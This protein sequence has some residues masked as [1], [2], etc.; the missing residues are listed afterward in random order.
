MSRPNFKPVD[1]FAD[2]TGRT[3]KVGDQ[4]AYAVTSGNMAELKLGTVVRLGHDPEVAYW[5]A[6]DIVVQGEGQSRL[7]HLAFPSRIVKVR[8]ALEIQL[9]E[10][11]AEFRAT[12]QRIMFN[13][14]VHEQ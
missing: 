11:E 12:P 2:R 1:D 14:E 7:S 3:V 10:R 6:W 8:T 13:G 5:R 9:A 4:I